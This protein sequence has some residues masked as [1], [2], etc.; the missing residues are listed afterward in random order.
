MSIGDGRG[1]GEMGDLL[2]MSS[3]TLSNIE[4]PGVDE[5]LILRGILKSACKGVGWFNIAVDRDE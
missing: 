4:D 3:D 2:K 5:M 1:T